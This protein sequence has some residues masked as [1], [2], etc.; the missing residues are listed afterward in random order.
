MVFL[1]Y[2]VGKNVIWVL[3]RN[4]YAVKIEVCVQVKI[5]SGAGECLLLRYYSWYQNQVY[6]N[7]FAC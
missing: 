1:M 7:D 5:V 6:E 2:K 3:R 4:K